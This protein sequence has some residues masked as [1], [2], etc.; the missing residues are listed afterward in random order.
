M[1]APSVSWLGLSASYTDDE[2][3]LMSQLPAGE[4]TTL[5]VLKS[6]C[7]G[8]IQQPV[9]SATDAVTKLGLP[10]PI[11]SLVDDGGERGSSP[12]T[13]MALEAI[14]SNAKGTKWLDPSEIPFGDSRPL[15]TVSAPVPRRAKKTYAIVWSWRKHR[16]TKTKK[17]AQEKVKV[18]CA[19]KRRQG[20]N[21]YRVGEAYFA[22]KDG[23]REA[24]LVHTYDR[25]TRE[26][27]S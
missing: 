9:V 24:A 12:H 7:S 5:H 23:L 19:W 18:W 20:W 8:T 4:Q 21:V 6:L 16:I 13:G 26:R 17:R 1:E 27:I 2:R 11:E 14:Q 22:D 10:K 3:S 25:E 15:E